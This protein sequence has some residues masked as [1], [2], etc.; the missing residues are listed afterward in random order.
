M[1]KHKERMDR[2]GGRLHKDLDGIIMLHGTMTYVSIPR[3]DEI[4]IL[5]DIGNIIP[6]G[7]VI[8][9]KG[10]CVQIIDNMMYI[11]HDND[12]EATWIYSNPWCSC[13]I[14]SQN[15]PLMKNN[16]MYGYNR[17]YKYI[18]YIR[19]NRYNGYGYNRYGYNMNNRYNG[20]VRYPTVPAA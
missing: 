8:Y 20:Q 3:G 17:Y 4:V 6:A 11:R 9:H 19:Y 13:N 16:Y 12:K 7:T 10:R 15:M 18:E 14:C 1:R 2:N 5:G